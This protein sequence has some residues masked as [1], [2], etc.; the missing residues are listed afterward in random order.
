MNFK[1]LLR[2]LNKCFDTLCHTAMMHAVYY[3]LP[4]WANNNE[5]FALRLFFPSVMLECGFSFFFG[6]LYSKYDGM[7]QAG[8]SSSFQDILISILFLF[9]Q[10]GWLCK[11][12]TQYLHLHA[13]WQFCGKP[14]QKRIQACGALINRFCWARPDMFIGSIFKF[15]WP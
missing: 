10:T 13:T 9:A 8:D 7:F 6:P 11:F 14:F 12:F 5:Y 15:K 3:N 4:C 1:E 2:L